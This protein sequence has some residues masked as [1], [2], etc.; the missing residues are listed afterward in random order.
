M[1]PKETVF[2]EHMSSMSPEVSHL[3]F[4][5]SQE[6]MCYTATPCFGCSYVMQKS[7]GWL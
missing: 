3:I 4:T 6:E 1:L 2:I 7:G 5:T